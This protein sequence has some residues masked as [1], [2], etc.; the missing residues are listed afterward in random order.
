MRLTRCIRLQPARLLYS[1]QPE[2][3][4]V[5]HRVACPDPPT[6][7]CTGRQMISMASAAGLTKMVSKLSREGSYRKGLEVFEALPAV[8]LVRS[9]PR[10]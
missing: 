3:V 7:S 2:H 5:H 8:G 1:S 4:L 10:K 9:Q 6:S